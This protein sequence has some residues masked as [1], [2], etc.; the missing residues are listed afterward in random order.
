MESATF[1]YTSMILMTEKFF[2]W[3][4]RS[5]RHGLPHQNDINHA[6]AVLEPA[7]WQTSWAIFVFEAWCEGRGESTD[8]LRIGTVEM[9]KKLCRFIME[10]QWQDRETYPSKTVYGIVASI[11]RYLCRNGCHKISFLNAYFRS[12]PT[13]AW[14]TNEGAYCSGSGNFEYLVY[15]TWNFKASDLINYSSMI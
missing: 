14:R 6:I 12:T 13:N 2:A 11:Q 5:R 3:A 1:T 15:L 7:Q 8:L 4:K 10:A 9:E